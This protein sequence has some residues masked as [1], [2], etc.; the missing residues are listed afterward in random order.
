MAGWIPG[1]HITFWSVLSYSDSDSLQKVKVASRQAIDRNPVISESRQPTTTDKLNLEPTTQSNVPTHSYNLPDLVDSTRTN[2]GRCHCTVS[3]SRT[4]RGGRCE[5]QSKSCFFCFHSPLPSTACDLSTLRYPQ[6]MLLYDKTRQEF[7]LETTCYDFQWKLSYLY[8]RSPHQL[9]IKWHGR[10]P[11]L[12]P[13]LSTGWVD[14]TITPASAS[15]ALRSLIVSFTDSQSTTSW[16]PRPLLAQSSEPNQFRRTVEPDQDEYGFQSFNCPQYSGSTPTAPILCSPRRRTAK[17][18][19]GDEANS[20]TYMEA[21]L[22]KS[23]YLKLEVSFP[24][25]TGP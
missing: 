20:Q 2:R 16:V 8:A 10:N 5:A 11:A 1:M 17:S 4:S 19:R 7:R 25:I 15:D 23:S 12:N 6:G 22:R 3:G 9:Q 24:L 18:I 14:K 21:P 13:S